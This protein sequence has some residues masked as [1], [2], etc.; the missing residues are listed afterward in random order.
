MT[1]TTNRE[2]AVE[3]PCPH[4]ADHPNL[5]EWLSL[6]EP[7]SGCGTKAGHEHLVGC[8]HAVCLVTGQQRE[9]C[10]SGFLPW[11]DED[12]ASHSCGDDMWPGFDRAARDAI[13][14]G[15]FTTL[16]STDAVGRDH[17]DAIPDYSRLHR[18]ADWDSVTHTWRPLH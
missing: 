18:D 6:G 9:A 13:N 8:D 10:Q 16:G 4:I 15:W 11:H 12:P 1:D 17:P 5:M 7:C 3:N 2:P 14:A